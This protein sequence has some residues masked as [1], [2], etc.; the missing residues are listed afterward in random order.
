MAVGLTASRGLVSSLPS[1]S[2]HIEIVE[3]PSHVW[4]VL[5]LAGSL[6]SRPPLTAEGKVRPQCVADG[7]GHEAPQHNGRVV[8]LSS[9]SFFL[10]LAA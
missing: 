10:S 1:L 3:G 8:T 7:L 4:I 9:L 5:A 2:T 6:L